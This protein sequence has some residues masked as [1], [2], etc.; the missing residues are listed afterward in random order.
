MVGANVREEQARWESVHK[1]V[2]WGDFRS[3]GE[4]DSAGRTSVRTDRRVPTTLADDYKLGLST[5]SN[6]QDR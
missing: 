5:T 6:P 1:T 2:I 3:R 4:D